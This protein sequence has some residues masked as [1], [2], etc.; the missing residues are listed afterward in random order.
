[1]NKRIGILALAVLLAMVVPFVVRAH[2]GHKHSALGT[3]ESVQGVHLQLK[4]T[5]GKTITL[6][7]DKDTTVTRGKE[8][9]DANAL[10]RG[11]R[12]AVD[13]S[14]EGAMLMAHAIRLGA[15]K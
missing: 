5:D 7:L 2:D 10:K 4:K 12:A 6:M 8:K 15:T 13:Y 14:D 9:L 11:E 3:I 1:M